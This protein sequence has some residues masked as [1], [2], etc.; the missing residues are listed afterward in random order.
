[1]VRFP[2]LAVL[3]ALSLP[4]QPPPGLTAIKAARLFDGKADTLVS[5]GL[6]VVSD[7]K[8]VQVGGSAPA[9]ARL[10]DLGDATLLPGFMDAHTH[11]TFDPNTFT[12]AG[13]LGNMAKTPAEFAIESAEN[14]RKTLLAGFTTVRNLG[15]QD[16]VDI[17]LR[18]AINRG[19]TPGPRILTA[20]KSLGTTGGHCDPTNGARPGAAPEPD[21]TQGI[22]NSPDHFRAAVR[23]QIKAGADLIKV[24]ATGGVLSLNND[25]DSSQLT[26]DELSAIASEAHA[27][28][29]KVAAHAHGDE[30]ARR[31]V[32][33]GIDSIEHGSFLQEPTLDL[34]KQRG[35]FYVPTLHALDSIMLGLE[36]GV[37]MDPRNVAKARKA[38][39]S[40]HATFRKA[41]Q[42]GVRI[43]FGTDV[44]VGEHGANAREFRLMVQ[45]GL[46]PLLALKAATSI[47]AELFGI[48]SQTGTLESGKLA[49]I[50]AVPGNPL[51]DITVTE[52]VLFV[53]KEGAVYRHD[54]K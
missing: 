41:V 29:R 5:P 15:A 32:A 2:A 7:G 47:D 36:K 21:W 24:C 9:G 44:G 22:A 10:I 35:T 16:F 28:G 46:S 27:K 31:A 3:A 11:L 1:M 23:Y 6:V 34:M 45:H 37:Q 8:I 38:G 14:A 18:N 26:Q 4:A 54:R 33:A 20:G 19:L 42:R 17:G 13:R 12:P 50:V 52:R 53:M 39:D 25:V 49:D 43:A 40:I 48:A 30:G 51:D